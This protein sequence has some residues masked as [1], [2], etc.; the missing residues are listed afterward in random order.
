[1]EEPITYTE[2]AYV[3]FDVKKNAVLTTVHGNLAI[4]STLAMA[5]AWQIRSPLFVE[6]RAVRITPEAIQ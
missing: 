1:M 5:K 4:F 3:L 2:L 6:V